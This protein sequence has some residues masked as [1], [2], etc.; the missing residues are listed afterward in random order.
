[1]EKAHFPLCRMVSCA[2]TSSGD[3]T[4]RLDPP[5]FFSLGRR[6]RE[7]STACYWMQAPLYNRLEGV[8]THAALR[9]N[10][11]AAKRA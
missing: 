10:H 5:F 6:F 9:T 11:A 1:M 2:A 4:M 7:E 8:V 3:V